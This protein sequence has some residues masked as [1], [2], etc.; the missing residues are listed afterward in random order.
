MPIHESSKVVKKAFIKIVFFLNL[1]AVIALIISYGSV[2]IPPDTFWI[3]SLFGLA[4]PF[5]LIA[6]IVFVVFWLLVKPRNLLLSLVFILLGWNFIGRYIQ[7]GV[8]K[9]EAGDIKVLSYN[10]GHFYGDGTQKVNENSSAIVSFLMKQNPDIVCLQETRLRKKNIF[11]LPETIKKLKSINHYQYARSSNTFGMVTMTRYPIVNMQE[12]RFEESRNMAIYTDVII[13]NDT[14]RIFNV[15]L[16]SYKIDPRKYSIIESLGISEE[17][18]IEEVKEM[19][20]KFKTAFQQRAKQV[21][22]IRKCLDESPYHV[23][24]CG[25]FNDTPASF[26]YK[27]LG[28]NL[29]DAFVSSG[30]GIGRTYIGKLPSFRIDYIL[31]SKSFESFNFE[32][33]DFKHSDHLP[34]TCDL[35][36]LK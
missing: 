29:Q 1:L 20:M 15:H 12:I 16:Q 31:H 36:K 35:V 14:V 17:K 5:V 27:H 32:T 10:V 30:K 33:L 13:D 2:Y 23:I 34:I 18:D 4:Y 7:L 25:D 21:R 22:E 9:V 19:G 11:N 24:L 28:D 26:S 6:N 8:E 3:P